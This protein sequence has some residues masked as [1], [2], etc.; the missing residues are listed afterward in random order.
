MRFVPASSAAALSSPADPWVRQARAPEKMD[1]LPMADTTKVVNK[2]FR[3]LALQ[4]QYARMP[5]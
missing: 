2:A 3:F 4:S 1:G 5:H